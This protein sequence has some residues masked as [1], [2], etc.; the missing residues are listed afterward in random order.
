[1]LGRAKSLLIS[2]DGEKY[3]PEGI[4]EAFVGNSRYIDQIML[5]NNQ[6]TYTAALIVPN[7]DNLL[8][9]LKSHNL[10]IHTEEGQDTALRLLESEI[11]QYQKR[12]HL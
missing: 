3:S 6:S 9:Y 12:G 7:K 5:Y 10:T 1:M 11:G 2:H 8:G 4:E